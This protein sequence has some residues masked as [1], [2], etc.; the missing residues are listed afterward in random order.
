MKK[1]PPPRYFKKGPAKG[2]L[3]SP[4]SAARPSGP[5]KAKQLPPDSTLREAEYLKSLVTD[6][7]QVRVRLQDNEEVEGVIEYYDTHL[8]RLTREG[9]PNLFIYKREIKY[10]EEQD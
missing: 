8:I 6:K 3:K 2:P 1:K 10:L 5:P 9:E 7:T 4:S